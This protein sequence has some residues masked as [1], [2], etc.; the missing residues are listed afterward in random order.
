MSHD[1][2]QSLEQR[3]LLSGYFLIDSNFPSQGVA[4]PITGVT[5]TFPA[6]NLLIGN[7]VWGTQYADRIL[8]YRDGAQTVV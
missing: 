8:V 6:T 2:F 1:L 5:A 4:I 7:S 3:R